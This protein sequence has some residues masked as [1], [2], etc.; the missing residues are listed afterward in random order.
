MDN[1]LSGRTPGRASARR[2]I[3]LTVLTVLAM[4][5]AV[6]AQRTPAD[7]PE[8]APAFRFRKAVLPNATYLSRVIEAAAERRMEAELTA[9]P[10]IRIQ[11]EAPPAPIDERAAAY[12]RQYGISTELARSIIQVAL[13]E[14]LDPELA[15]RLVRTES[16]FKTRA[17]GPQGALGLTQLMPSTARV[18]D[19]SV[20]TEAQIL[21]PATNL[22]LGFRYLRQM[23]V[24]Y[25]GDV[26]L[27]LLAY[28][29]GEVSVDRA[30][31]SGRDPENGYSHKVLG[32]RGKSPY[33]GK[34]LVGR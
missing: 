17:R 18:I 1:F 13:D 3:P 33:R 24:R 27:G 22:R 5:S 2:A 11:V 21:D 26:R 20:R 8:A 6:A 16:R 7:T 23:I 19:R 32:T 25:D 15:F 30:L 4:S 34:G 9:A 14:G 10:E 31:R 28:N 12:A 29:R